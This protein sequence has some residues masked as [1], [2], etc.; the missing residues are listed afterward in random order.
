MTKQQL[1]SRANPDYAQNFIDKRGEK[2]YDQ[3]LS[4]ILVDFA[5]EV[6]EP[7]EIEKEDTHLH[8]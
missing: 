3:P 2:I 5:R 7:R 6:I 1:L 8:H 4:E